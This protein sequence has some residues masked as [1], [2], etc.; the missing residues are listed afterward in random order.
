MISDAVLLLSTIAITYFCAIAGI[1][2]FM[3]LLEI[4][5]LYFCT[6]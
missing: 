4:D 6:K 5:N 1:V 3:R 2:L